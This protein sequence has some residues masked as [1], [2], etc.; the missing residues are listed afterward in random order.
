[1][2]SRLFRPGC[3]TMFYSGL[4]PIYT[5][6]IGMRKSTSRNIFMGLSAS[7]ENGCMRSI[8]RKSEV[9]CPQAGYWSG[10]SRMDG[11]RY[12]SKHLRSQ[13]WCWMIVTI[14]L[15][16]FLG[17]ETPP[18]PFPSGNKPVD[19]LGRFYL[20]MGKFVS[21]ANRNFLICLACT[22][23][24]VAYAVYKLAVI[25][26]PTMATSVSSPE[27]VQLGRCRNYLG[28]H[29]RKKQYEVGS[30]QLRH[31]HVARLLLPYLKKKSKNTYSKGICIK[32]HE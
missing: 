4:M 5:G 25:W 24:L 13:W 27:K 7:M 26:A 21:A 31:S 19:T 14:T 28:S 9:L 11:S 1:M 32:Q 16:R 6:R 18:E 10:M 2:Y 20:T 12:A 8:A 23:G 3:C 15:C 22:G 29:C 30:Y 17:K